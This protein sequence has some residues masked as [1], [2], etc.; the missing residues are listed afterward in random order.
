MTESLYIDGGKLPVPHKRR[1]LI[2]RPVD[3]VPA[4]TGS[5]DAAKLYPIVLEIAKE[6]A[7]KL[8]LL[9]AALLKEDTDE[10]YRIAG[11]LCGLGDSYGTGD[12]VN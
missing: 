3:D 10:V 8:V 6:R 4:T 9:K 7:E 2:P 12:R 11:S 1:I 5:V